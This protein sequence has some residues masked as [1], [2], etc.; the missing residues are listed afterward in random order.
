MPDRALLHVAVGPFTFQGG[1][2][3]PLVDCATL[4]EWGYDVWGFRGEEMIRDDVDITIWWS[5]EYGADLIARPKGT[6]VAFLGD[7]HVRIPD[8]S[9][10]DVVATD[11]R[12][13][14]EVGK[15]DPRFLWWRGFSY[16]PG[17]HFDKEL[18]LRTVDVA[19]WGRPVPG[20]LE[21]THWLREWAYHS[22]YTVDLNLGVY[23]RG[24]EAPVYR[25]AKVVLG[26]SQRG[27]LQMRAYEAMA[28]GALYVVQH[29]CGEVFA[30]G[31]PI[32]TYEPA[33]VEPFLEYWLTHEDA[34][35]AQVE[36]Q[37]AWVANE[38]PSRHLLW[39]LDQ[40][41]ERLEGKGRG[42]A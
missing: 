39:L 22:G 41:R 14:R 13:V 10:F 34:R 21:L 37:R 16:D 38:T 6:F 40:I 15:G 31:A 26:H 28:C 12:G 4:K 36:R 7:W 1:D 23:G 25:R 30:S 8:L 18:P 29:D 2:D 19:L 5:P 17:L 3:W 32:P 35:H 20:R 9:I 42:D 33:Q 11:R 24:E 27:E